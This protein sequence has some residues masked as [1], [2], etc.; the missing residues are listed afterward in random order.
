VLPLFEQGLDF[1]A[2]FAPA[3]DLAG[4]ALSVAGGAAGFFMD[5]VGD[6]SIEAF[7]GYVEWSAENVRWLAEGIDA[8]GSTLGV[9]DGL[10]TIIRG[11]GDGLG[12]VYS[13]AENAYDTLASGAEWVL[14]KILDLHNA[15]NDVPGAAEMSSF[16]SE[17]DIAMPDLSS[18]GP[19]RADGEGP[20]PGPG[21]PP[22][23]SAA[24][25]ESSAIASLPSNTTAAS[26]PP[27]RAASGTSSTASTPRPSSGTSSPSSTPPATT[28]SVASG[29]TTIHN[30][31]TVEGGMPRS[32]ARLNRMIRK[33]HRQLNKRQAKMSGSSTG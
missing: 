12:F 18:I 21:T 8:I 4:D 33:I 9:W 14:G 11:V 25:V 31:I 23:A 5:A 22:S 7:G 17:E 20:G 6:P 27:S 32:D 19:D 13:M 28:S 2:A 1:L 30:N 24:A 16:I 3:A 26:Q 10:A 15:I 29:G